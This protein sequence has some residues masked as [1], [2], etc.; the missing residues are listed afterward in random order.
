MAFQSKNKEMALRKLGYFLLG[1]VY[2]CVCFGRIYIP[3][4]LFSHIHVDRLFLRWNIIFEKCAKNT[5]FFRKSVLGL[6]Y[7]RKEVPYE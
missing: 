4:S 1:F 6:I 2:R 5:C 3:F 7:Q